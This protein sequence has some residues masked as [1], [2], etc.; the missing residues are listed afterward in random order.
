MIRKSF[1]FLWV[2]VSFSLTI[3]TFL[4]AA[5][6]NLLPDTG[7]T[8]C[9]GQR[10]IIPCPDEGG[11][12]YGQDAQYSGA[13]PSYTS[14][15]INED[16]VVIDNNTSLVW[17][18]NTADINLDGQITTSR[19]PGG[20][21]IGQLEATE[22]C[23]NLN[24]AGY[25]DWRLPE[26][27]ELETIVNY[28]RVSAPVIH[29]VFDSLSER[30]W[31]ATPDDVYTF[32]QYYW[33]ISFNYGETSNTSQYNPLIRCVRGDQTTR[34]AYVDNNN[35]T[36]TDRS[37]GLTWQQNTAD[38]NNDGSITSEHYPAGDEKK[39]PDALAWCE[40]S[41]FAGYSDWRLPNVR[42]LFS[43]VDTTTYDPSI[44]YTFQCEVD[45]YW[46]ATG[47]DNSYVW[48]VNFNSGNTDQLGES[49]YSLLRC[50]RDGLPRLLTQTQVSQLYVSIFG[51]ASEGEGNDYWKSDPG[52]ISM[53]ITA[54]TML[55]TEPAKAYFGDTLNDNQMF[56]EFI[57]KNT[58][59]KTYAE[60]PAG[61]N[62][63]VG[64]LAGGKSK[65][66]VVATLINAAMDPQYTGLPAQDQFMNKVAVSN[67][68]AINIITI[69]DVN[70][71]SAFV[72]FI[73][74]VT[75]DDATVTAAKAT[76]DAF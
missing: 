55:N 52:S 23:A 73:S 13:A 7:Q 19:Y 61:V 42:E 31:S 24:F 56:I 75:D 58:L 12:Y 10:G 49:N 14:L 22:Y 70:D 33:T 63:W 48:V 32:T 59:G 27:E 6:W 29:P 45:S 36:I 9:V 15:V 69:P 71:L 50:V 26:I 66:Q 41:T 25:S 57:Y 1:F 11:L 34:G 21:Y 68:T 17:Q 62:Y 76:V 74:D 60:D 47:K 3:S 46:S 4:F 67:Y 37:T 65:G 64:E 51:R 39:W 8:H 38:T 35:G 16:N 20:D 54:N 28:G 43:L 18:Q 5:N 53:A 72:A 40:T 44:H 2:I 30:Y